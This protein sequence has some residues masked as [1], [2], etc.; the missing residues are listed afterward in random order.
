MTSSA[1]PGNMFAAA[2]DDERHKFRELQEEVQLRSD[3]QI[4]MGQETEN[5]MVAQELNLMEGPTAVVYK[6][7]GPVL[8][9]QDLEESQQTVKKRLEFIK[10][11]QRKVTTKIQEKENK[12]Q[13][14]YA[15]IQKMQQQLQQTTVE[16]VKAIQEQHA[17]GRS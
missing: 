14:L 1:N 2:A 17:Q 16:A 8:I 10:D 11:E 5:E 15:S 4:L 7:I 12:G 9:K 3:L 13:Q 6:M